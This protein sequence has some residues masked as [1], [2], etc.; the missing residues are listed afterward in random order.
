MSDVYDQVMATLLPEAVQE[1]V[2]HYRIVE[3]PTFSAV[4]SSTTT[5]I[6]TSTTVVTYLYNGYLS[7]GSAFS[8]LL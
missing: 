8:Y 4:A 1:P 2:G 3:G 7:N 6:V 5:G